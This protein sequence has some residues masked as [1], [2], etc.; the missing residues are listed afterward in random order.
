MY[1]FQGFPDEVVFGLNPDNY[2]SHSTNFELNLRKHL[3]LFLYFTVII[4]ALVVCY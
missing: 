1:V 3:L 2:V 4:A